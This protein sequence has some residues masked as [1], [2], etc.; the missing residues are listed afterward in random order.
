MG[1]KLELYVKEARKKFR[2]LSREEEN[3]LILKAQQGDIQARNEV[4]ERHLML[5]LKL[6]HHYSGDLS[7]LI[8]EG[9]MALLRAVHDFDTRF[10]T[11]F[12][13]YAGVRIK[14]AFRNYIRRAQ[15]RYD[16]AKIPLEKI[17]HLK[18]PNGFSDKIIA[19]A[20]I[21]NAPI[22]DREKTVLRKRLQGY[23]YKEIS[24]Q[25]GV[26]KQTVLQDK[27]RAIKIINNHERN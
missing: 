11:R 25:L 1:L 10:G 14:N 5:V 9:N 27:E 23:R 19:D 3:E 7:D 15:R 26:S 24:A 8:Y 16:H 18:S 4:V 12:I 13:T 17:Y 21:E 22:K 6:A 2:K 20:I